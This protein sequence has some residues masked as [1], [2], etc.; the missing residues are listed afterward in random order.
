EAAPKADG[1]WACFA[2]G[3]EFGWLPVSG[4]RTYWFATAW[5]PEGGAS[6]AEDRAY[7]SATFGGWPDP[8]P[9]LIASTPDGDFVRSEITDRDFLRSWTDGPVTLLGDAAHPMRPHLGQ[10]GCQAIE[11]AAALAASLSGPADPAAAF[12]SYARRRRRRARA[13]VRG[14]RWAGF[15]RPPGR[16][17]ELA[18]GLM[19]RVPALNVSRA[20]F[21]LL[22]PVAGYR[23]GAGAAGPRG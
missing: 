2:S 17:T 23:A 21:R 19:R 6:Q 10:G 8:V 15:T 4:G 22:A 3:H 11:D 14:S 5:L 7:L 9:S 13:V 12:T 16:R 1:I 20:A 18:D